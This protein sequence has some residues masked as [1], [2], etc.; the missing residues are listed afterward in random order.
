MLRFFLYCFLVLFS[1]SV[2]SQQQQQFSTNALTGRG[3]LVLV[4]TSFKLQKEAFEAYKK[5]K[6][7]ALK[8]GINIKIVS[9]Y[10][11]FN[12]QKSIWNRKYNLYTS[13]GL[14][15]NDAIQKIVEYSTIPGTSRHHWGTDIDIIDASVKAPKNLLIENNYAKKGVYAKLKK[16]METNA[17]T[18]GFY[19]VYTNNRTRN[20]FKYEPWH[21]TY[22]PLSKP[23]L[24]EFKKIDLL[25]FYKGLEL[26]GN[27]YLTK[28]FLVKYL[29]ENILDINLSLI[30]D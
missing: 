2:L 28:E 17:E 21:Y 22:K 25:T 9:A 7:A 6:K 12:R 26:N 20:G 1:F 23:M 29:S 18:F 14:S 13:Q 8:E 15:P 3:D 11:S 5:M 4:G 27:Q 16:W 10:R 19:L 30:M 24:L